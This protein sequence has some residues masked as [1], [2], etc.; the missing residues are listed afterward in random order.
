LTYHRSQGKVTYLKYLLESCVNTDFYYYYGDLCILKFRWLYKP[1]NCFVV[2][3]IVLHISAVLSKFHLLTFSITSA[4]WTGSFVIL[5]CTFC[6]IDSSYMCVCARVYSILIICP[7]N[8]NNKISSLLGPSTLCC[9]ILYYSH[10]FLNVYIYILFPQFFKHL[11]YIF[12]SIEKTDW[13]VSWG[14]TTTLKPWKE[15]PWWGLST[16][17]TSC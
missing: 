16:S 1:R 14:K 6:P 17:E 13:W 8:T 3:N 10:S 11:T 2:W 9:R 15:V 12:K 5:H 4:V 7:Y